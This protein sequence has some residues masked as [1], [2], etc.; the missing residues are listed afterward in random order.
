MSE[1]DVKMSEQD[2][3][4]SFT[5]ILRELL[6]N[7]EIVLGMETRREDVPNW[8]S[9]NYINFIVAVEMKLGVKFNVADVESFETVGQIVA[10]TKKMLG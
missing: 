7:D 10:Q 8:D 5:E 6:M 4:E 3:L 1:Q 9:L 2:I